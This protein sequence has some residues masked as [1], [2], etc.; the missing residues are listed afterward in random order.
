MFC[1]RR[2]PF[3]PVIVVHG[4]AMI[5]VSLQRLLGTLAI[6]STLLTAS[7]FAD[8]PDHAKAH[9]WRKKHDAQ[10]VG[11]TGREWEHDYGVVEGHCDRKEVG[12]VIGG[13]A[14]GVIGS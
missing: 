10:Y 12:T 14:G 2:L 5:C 7:I 3:A 8:P 11:Y 13:V 1:L 4:A 6:A 9:G